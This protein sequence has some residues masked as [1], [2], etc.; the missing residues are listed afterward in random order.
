[1]QAIFLTA[2]ALST[3]FQPQQHPNS[4]SPE[5]QIRSF[6]RTQSA[7]LPQDVWV[8]IL[9]HVDCT[10]RLSACALVCQ[11]LARA[12]A[13][14]AAATQSFRLYLAGSPRY[15][16][17]LGWASSHGSSL[18]RLELLS[19]D[20][21]IREL[22]CPNLLELQLYEASV[23]A[24][25]AGL[26]LLH[27]CTALTRLVL[28]RASLL[29]GVGGLSAA[30]PTAAAARLKHLDLQDCQMPEGS[31]EAGRV[32]RALQDRLFPLLSCLTQLKL[33]GGH[34]DNGLQSCFLRHIS[35]LASLQE[36]FLDNTGA[37][38]RQH[39]G[40]RHW[41]QH[42]MFVGKPGVGEQQCV[43]APVSSTEKL[44]CQGQ[45]TVSTQSAHVE[46]QS[47]LPVP[48]C[49]LLLLLPE[50]AAT[51]SLTAATLPGIERLTA[52]EDLRLSF[53][54]LEP[55]CLLPM[56]TGLTRLWLRDVTL[57]PEQA[58]QDSALGASQLLRAL[59][60]LS[61]LWELTL[62][63]I[64][65]DW[66]Q[67]Q[68]AQYSALT[69]SSNL[70]E[71]HI[72]NSSIPGTA[73]A[74]V[75]SAGRSLPQLLSFSTRQYDG[76]GPAPMG[77]ADITRLA[78]CCPALKELW[79]D[80]CAEVSLSP[81]QSLTA[82]T[83]LLLEVGPVSP[84][85]I[86][87]NLAALSQLRDLRFGISQ[88]VPGPDSVAGLGVQGLLPL[89]ALTGLTFLWTWGQ[90]QSMP[91]LKSRVSERRALLSLTA[92]LVWVLPCML[93]MGRLVALCAAGSMRPAP[94][95]Q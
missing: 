59:G 52:L 48:P 38:G 15:D 23:C 68:L 79:I 70:R 4:S 90:I 60:R 18:T 88:P 65:G 45:H 47:Q 11:K 24:G 36:L 63:I 84:A 29:D 50:L 71:L 58:Q 13:A 72:S 55:S 35:T 17:F 74:H 64:D 32:A 75:F 91:L 94:C 7:E 77:C 86:R 37:V 22:P 81:L 51:V 6:S 56:A 93:W 73:W 53:C 5:W 69:A 46:L 8:Q 43:L 3:S 92:M 67:Q 83:S 14:A 89:T 31:E 10:Q 40:S 82:L 62:S 16:A 80:I 27:S 44:T 42:G 12:A 49:C 34:R 57:R 78:S 87:S 39:T 41:C 28:E 2:Y 76:R 9:Q 26:G 61:N 25:S 95:S 85:V 1:M 66:P 21:P 30:V 20:S 54:N 33:D 19:S